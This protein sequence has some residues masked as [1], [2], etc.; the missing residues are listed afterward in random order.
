MRRHKLEIYVCLYQ[1]SC[2][3]NERKILSPILMAP[4]VLG[5]MAKKNSF[6]ITSLPLVSREMQG[7]QE[8]H[9]S[10]TSLSRDF[11]EMH[12]QRRIQFSSDPCHVFTNE[13][14]AET[15]PISRSNPCLEL[16]TNVRQ[17]IISHL[18]PCH[19]FK[20]KCKVEKSFIS[21]SHPCLVFVDN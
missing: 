18:H 10:F 3:C 14:E 2:K 15:E 11:I 5:S 19:V 21:C 13:L 7:N 12:K 1:Q 20:D 8:I 16:K 4:G 9:F 17:P 6:L